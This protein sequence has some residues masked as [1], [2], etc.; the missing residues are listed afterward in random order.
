MASDIAVAVLGA[1]KMGLI[2]CRSIAS[3]P[4]L[5]LVAASS[6]A[7]ERLAAVREEF[8][9]ATY[10]SHEQ[11][12]ADRNVQW[13]VI[14]TTTDKHKHWALKALAAGKRLIIEKPVAL[15]Y[16]E[17]QEIFAEATRRKLA[18]T[19][20]QSRRWDNDFTLI[21]DLLRKGTLG[22]VY[23]IE[24]RY[25]DFSS[26]W[27]GWGAQ[28]LAN[29]WRL[30]K[31]YGGGLL[32]DW[33]THLLD[34]LLLLLDAEVVGLYAGMYG[35]IWTTE[36]DDHFW[37]ELD[38]AGGVSARVEASNNARIPL[39]RWYV[40]GTTGTLQVRGGDP[41]A[42]DAAVIRS[43]FEGRPQEIKIPID[44]PELSRGFYQEFVKALAEGGP[45][46]V[47]PSEVLK[48]MQLVDAMRESAES[49]RSVS[50][51]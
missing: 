46:P 29:P 12:L 3:T 50:F 11:L 27:G 38:F 23:R 42:W 18:V 9:V 26:G 8:D 22:E 13:V 33:G 32:A 40:V 35:R 17:A 20:Y 44:Q 16:P 41:T 24:S 25:T 39:P 47:Q 1:G 28:G 10:P 37:A 43:E 30:K 5:R 4:G 34:Q 6:G 21:R 31:A 51:E 45:L 7:P 48:V 19:V 14:A 36:V 2:H 49:G 15:S